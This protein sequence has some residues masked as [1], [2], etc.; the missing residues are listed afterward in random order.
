MLESSPP[1]TPATLFFFC[2]LKGISSSQRQC[3]EGTYVLPSS[4]PS[5]ETL[6]QQT[7]SS[8]PRLMSLPTTVLPMQNRGLGATVLGGFGQSPE[9]TLP[10][11]GPRSGHFVGRGGVGHQQPSRLKAHDLPMQPK[12]HHSSCIWRKVR[13][14]CS[15]AHLSFLSLITRI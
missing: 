4:H 14:V 12:S 11:Q 15:F 3:K 10:P 7:G 5:R 13:L 6:G 9:R 8:R 1:P 2:S